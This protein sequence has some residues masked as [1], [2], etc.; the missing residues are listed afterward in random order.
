MAEL[1]NYVEWS[2]RGREGFPHL[3]DEGRRK[4]PQNPCA[5]A[6]MSNAHRLEAHQ[7][8]TCRVGRNRIICKDDLSEMTSRAVKRTIS[9]WD[10]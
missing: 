5:L 1:S 6:D 8:C 10:L 4:V 9:F 2:C 3:I 7:S